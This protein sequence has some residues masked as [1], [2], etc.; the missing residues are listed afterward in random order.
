MS[1]DRQI[2]FK[3]SLERMAVMLHTNAPI[4]AYADFLC[5]FLGCKGSQARLHP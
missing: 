5:S 4:T 2:S 3:K 1:S